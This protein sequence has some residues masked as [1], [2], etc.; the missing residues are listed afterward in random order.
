MGSDINCSGR[1]V[2]ALSEGFHEILQDDLAPDFRESVKAFSTQV[3]RVLNKGFLKE[4][5]IL[6]EAWSLG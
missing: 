6:E 2:F 5:G 4:V 3:R 1:C